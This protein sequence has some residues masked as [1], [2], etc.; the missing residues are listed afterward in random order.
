MRRG[1]IRIV[2]GINHPADVHY[3]KNFVDK[4]KFGGMII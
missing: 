1:I 3:F 2:V 4:M